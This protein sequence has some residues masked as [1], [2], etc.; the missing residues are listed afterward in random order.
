MKGKRL[1]HTLRLWTISSGAKRAEYLRNKKIFAGIG[2]NC[3][4]M[5]RK[6]PL[7]ANLIRLGD[8]VHLA[9]NVAFITHDI[10]H[11]M[12][13]QSWWEPVSGKKFMEKIG[14]IEIGDNVFIGSGTT[15]LYDVKIGSNVIVGAGSVVTKDIPDNSIAVGVPARVISSLDSYVSGRINED[16]YGND[17]RPQNQEIGPELEKWCWDKFREKRQ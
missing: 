10:T 16:I 8:N 11:K 14:C 13:N 2:K 15:I 4:F 1:L 6:I 7:Y 5:D 3:T 9:S 12:L 17:I